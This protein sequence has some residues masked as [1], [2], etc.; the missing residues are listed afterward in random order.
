MADVV[1]CVG[2]LMHLSYF[3]QLYVVVQ[4]LCFDFPPQFVNRSCVVP[5]SERIVSIG[6][7]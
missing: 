5:K 2:Q 4:G 6:H 3:I 7:F 1:L